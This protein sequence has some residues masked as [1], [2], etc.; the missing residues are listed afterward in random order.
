MTLLCLVCLWT[1]THQLFILVLYKKKRGRIK[2]KLNKTLIRMWG[3]NVMHNFLHIREKHNVIHGSSIDGRK[4]TKYSWNLLLHHFPSIRMVLRDTFYWWFFPLSLP[5]SLSLSAAFVL[6]IIS[7]RER[8]ERRRIRILYF[9]GT[10]SFQ[11]PFF[12]LGAW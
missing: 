6:G 1:D 3:E 8:E 12:S 10:S 2:F 11:E 4:K 5:S 7:W 9:N